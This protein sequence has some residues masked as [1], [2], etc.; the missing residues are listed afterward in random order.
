MRLKL[1][2]FLKKD[3]IYFYLLG[4]EGGHVQ[5]VGQGE[6][7]SSRLQAELKVWD[8]GPHLTIL[9]RIMKWAEVESQNL[10]RLSHAGAPS[11]I[12]KETSG[13]N[14]EP[15]CR[16][17][18]EDEGA[19]SEGGLGMFRREEVPSTAYWEWSPHTDEGSGWV[20]SQTPQQQGRWGLNTVRGVSS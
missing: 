16:T 14:S 5:G 11:N 15:P 19:D 7:I 12:L 3:F 10:N 13:E 20:N 17:T 6:K 1:S 2:N 18:W 8:M 4:R 9:I